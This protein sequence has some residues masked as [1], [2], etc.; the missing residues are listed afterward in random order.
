M[1][2]NEGEEN[3]LRI[4]FE[5]EGEKGVKSIDIS[6]KLNVSKPA[7]SEMLRKLVNK[8]MILFQAYSKI[9]L[10]RKGKEHAEKVYHNFHKSKEIIKKI[11]SCEDQE[12]ENHA[13]KL[14]HTLISISLRKA[15]PSY[16]R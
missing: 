9:L 3:Y 16:I 5:L 8:K 13:H 15:S 7:V 12:A 10:T 6:K 2:I 11:L 14:E 4:I 1:N